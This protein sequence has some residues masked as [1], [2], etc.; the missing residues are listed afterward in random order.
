MA[1]FQ[2]FWLKERGKENTEINEQ[3][4]KALE[5]EYITKKTAFFT[6]HVFSKSHAD[7]FVQTSLSFVHLTDLTYREGTL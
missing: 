1:R 5:G 3:N 2:S 4:N 6:V 7:I